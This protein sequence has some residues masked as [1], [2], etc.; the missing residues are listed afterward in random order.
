MW[1]DEAE[2]TLLGLNKTLHCTLWWQ[3]HDLGLLCCSEYSVVQAKLHENID[4]AQQKVDHAAKYPK[5]KKKNPR[6][7]SC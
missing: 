3:Y 6:H 4:P 5:H 2:V 1:P 7:T